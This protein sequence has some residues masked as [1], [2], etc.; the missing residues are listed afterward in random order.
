[1]PIKIE[2][3][4]TEDDISNLI[5]NF[6]DH[7]LNSLVLFAGLDLDFAQISPL[8]ISVEGTGYTLESRILF[9]DPIGLTAAIGSRVDQQ[10]VVAHSRSISLLIIKPQ[11]NVQEVEKDVIASLELLELVANHACEWREIS[12]DEY[13]VLDSEFLKNQLELHRKKEMMARRGEV[14]EPFEAVH[15]ESSRDAKKL[16]G[17]L[18]PI[19]VDYDKLDLYGTKKIHRYLP[20]I[21]VRKLLKCDNATLLS[22]DLFDDDE[23]KI[24]EDLVVR[25]YLKKRKVAGKVH[26]FGLNEKTRRHFLSMS[27]QEL[28]RNNPSRK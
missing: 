9:S 26:Y 8:K 28:H 18:I 10:Y 2:S 11:L 19:Y 27:R 5:D 12:V 22:E 23:R 25:K 21:L 3:K 17:D 1:L 16:A 24:L 4:L 20:R 13:I 14:V 6:R 7:L 15:A